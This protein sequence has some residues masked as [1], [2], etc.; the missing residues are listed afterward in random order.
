MKKTIISTIL[1]T[2]MSVAAAADQYLV[3]QSR[4]GDVLALTL[5]KCP[6]KSEGADEF[7][8]AIYKGADGVVIPACW[9]IFQGMVF[10]VYLD[11]KTLDP[12]GQGRFPLDVFEGMEEIPPAKGEI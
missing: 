12:I 6:S 5:D 10:V 8:G 4:A 11:D 9:A 2:A 1:A 7:K 3:A